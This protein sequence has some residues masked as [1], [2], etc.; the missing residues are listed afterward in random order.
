MV[1]YIRHWMGRAYSGYVAL[2]NS[3]IHQLVPR[4]SK[5]ISVIIA[6]FSWGRVHPCSVYMQRQWP[7][8]LLRSFCGQ[9]ALFPSDH[10][11]AEAS[12]PIPSD[13]TVHIISFS[14]YYSYK[15]NLLLACFQQGIIAHLV[16][17]QQALLCGGGRGGGGGGVPLRAINFGRALHH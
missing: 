9:T 17:C 2:I 16:A 12:G 15:L 5:T 1:F 6:L 13:S 8:P 3:L 10:G 4:A 7:T 11:K 14:S